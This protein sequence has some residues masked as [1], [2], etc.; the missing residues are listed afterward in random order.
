MSKII[1]QLTKARLQIFTYNSQIEY[2]KQMKSRVVSF[3]KEFVQHRTFRSLI[4]QIKQELPR[5]LGY[6][7]AEVFMYDR[8]KNSLYCR[9]VTGH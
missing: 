5:L 6:E 2:K 7:E 3:V 1:A 9:S 8:Q 4:G